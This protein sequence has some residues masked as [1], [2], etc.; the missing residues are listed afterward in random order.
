MEIYSQGKQDFVDEC[1]SNDDSFSEE[2]W[3][4]GFEWICISLSCIECSNHNKNW[5]EHE[6]M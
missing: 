5:M 3:V 6:T 1:V 4:D 2:D